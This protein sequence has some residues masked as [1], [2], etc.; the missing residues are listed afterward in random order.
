MIQL[1]RRRS[2]K[3]SAFPK[4]IF[5]I[6]SLLAGVIL[7]TNIWMYFSVNQ[8]LQA[9]QERSE[10]ALVKGISALLGEPLVKRDYGVLDLRLQ[11]LLLNA[12]VLSATITDAKGEVLAMWARRANMSE[13]K[14]I[15]N[16]ATLILPV[17]VGDGLLRSQDGNVLTLW[18]PVR[19]Q[20][21]VGAVRL[22]LST[23]TAEPVLDAL[24]RNLALSVVFVCLLFFCVFVAIVRHVYR[25]TEAPEASFI[26]SN[27]L[28]SSSIYIDDLTK[29]PNRTA[30]IS[31]LERAI[32]FCHRQGGLLAVC[33]LNLD[34]FKQVNERLGRDVGDAVLAEVALR[35]RSTVRA[36]DAV[37]RLGGDEFVLLLGGIESQQESTYLLR[38]VLEC[39]NQPFTYGDEA[40]L[41][42]AS[43]GVSFY[44]H[45]SSPPEQIIEHAGQ[46]RL[47]AQNMGQNRWHFYDV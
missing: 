3:Q 42:G 38:R 33:L 20:S 23:Q 11:D 15:V 29:L 39:L 44:P 10:L 25:Q 30:V 16:Q 4:I 7:L 21:L 14:A 34:D 1:N 5:S 37:I 12:Q 22:E 47:L 45:D 36:D 8:T 24:R 26:S 19:T 17:H 46:A 2:A 40:I 43:M 28:L 35:L 13:P 31:L 32:G 6:I 41:L 18:Y 27:D 9:T